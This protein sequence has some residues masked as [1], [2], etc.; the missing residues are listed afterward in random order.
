MKVVQIINS[1]FNSNTY[2]L[3]TE[4][5]DKVWIVDIGDSKPVLSWIRMNSKQIAGVFITHS[6][7]DHIYGLNE[8]FRYFPSMRVYISQEGAIGLYSEK[9]NLSKY[10]NQ[11][12]V[13]KGNN[14]FIL[15]DSQRVIL[16]DGIELVV[17]KTPGHDWSCLSY[18]I[19]GCLFT[20]D[21]YI[22]GL[23]TITSFPKSSKKDADISIKLL[24]NQPDV[25]RIYP[26]HGSCFF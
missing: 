13:Y 25:N 15:K 22:P 17:L 23:K 10:H 5:S 14:V 26:G 21:S 24:K 6:H 3:Y 12:F 20:G 1:L 19:G 16:W 11:P 18:K 7:F 8:I 9:L 4:S 2:I